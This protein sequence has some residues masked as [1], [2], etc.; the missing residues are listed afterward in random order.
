[1]KKQR[2][3]L[4]VLGIAEGHDTEFVGGDCEG[5]WRDEEAAVMGQVTPGEVAEEVQGE[6]PGA[7]C[8]YGVE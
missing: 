3:V 1:M 4:W 2:E 5:G 8:A 7:A 6:P